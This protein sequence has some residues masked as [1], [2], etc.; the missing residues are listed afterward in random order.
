MVWLLFRVHGGEPWSE[1]RKKLMPMMCEIA[2]EE[3]P[4][5]EWRHPEDNRF[6]KAI[7]TVEA[8]VRGEATQEKVNSTADAADATA[9]WVA[10]ARGAWVAASAASVTSVAR[11]AIVRKH[12]PTFP[13]AL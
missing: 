3:L 13:E 2:R 9:A 10:A 7:E 5:F 1:Q 8:W 6:R 11:G 12:F 4:L